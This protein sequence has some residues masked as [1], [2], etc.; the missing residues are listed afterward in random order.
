MLFVLVYPSILRMW[1]PVAGRDT[2]AEADGGDAAARP[3]A[4]PRRMAAES[5]EAHD[6]RLEF[7]KQI[8]QPM[9]I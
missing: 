1:D 8:D 6:M 9:M 4:T 3:P 2:M 5:S 7:G